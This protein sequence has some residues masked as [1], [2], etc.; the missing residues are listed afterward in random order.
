MRSDVEN[1]TKIKATMVIFSTQWGQV[2]LLANTCSALVHMLW[3]SQTFVVETTPICCLES[4]EALFQLFIFFVTMPYQFHDCASRFLYY[5]E[6]SSDYRLKMNWSN[7]SVVSDHHRDFDPG[8]TRKKNQIQNI[9]KT[10]R[11]TTSSL[12]KRRMSG[13]NL[14]TGIGS[15]QN[16]CGLI[17]Q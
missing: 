17:L 6:I 4:L 1:N 16:W 14:S 9:E 7:Y 3:N 13:P 11:S 2:T 12:E 5:F 15:D 10:A 8:C